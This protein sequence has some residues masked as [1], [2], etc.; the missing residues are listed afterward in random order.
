M[1]RRMCRAHRPKPR[2]DCQRNGGQKIQ[3]GTRTS[4]NGT[5]SCGNNLW[6]HLDNEVG[7]QTSNVTTDFIIEVQRYLAEGNMPRSQ[8]LQ[9]EILGQPKAHL[10]KPL[11]PVTNVSVYTSLICA[12]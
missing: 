8:D 9:E 7:M 3:G 1:R 6:Q 2:V 10:P 4:E 5:A 12:V 11:P